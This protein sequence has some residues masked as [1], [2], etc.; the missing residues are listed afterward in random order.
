MVYLFFYLNMALATLVRAEPIKITQE[1]LIEFSQSKQWLSYLQYY[2]DSQSR[3]EPNSKFFLS[4]NGEKD[5]LSELQA[6]IHVFTDLTE[7]NQKQI[8]QFPA[9]YK[10]LQTF[11]KLAI[12]TVN[13]PSLEEFDQQYSHQRVQIVFAGQ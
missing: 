7:Q 3:I 10:M 13:C 4:E 9:R 12:T 11:F 1:S 5:P 6:S 8:C 2:P